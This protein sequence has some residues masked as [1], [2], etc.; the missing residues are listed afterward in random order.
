MFLHSI[1]DHQHSRDLITMASPSNLLRVVASSVEIAN[2]AGAAIRNIMASGNLA[3]VD[4][5]DSGK[6]FDPQTEAD[7]T[8]QRIIVGSLE[9]KYPGLCVI[10]EEDDKE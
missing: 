10:E 5:D 3:V 1:S 6:E 7:R 9:K 8:A 2:R 4:K